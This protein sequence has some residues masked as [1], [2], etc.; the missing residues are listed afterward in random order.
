MRIQ[1]KRARPLALYAALLCGMIFSAMTLTGKT[2]YAACNCQQLAQ[3]VGAYCAEYG[4]VQ[5]FYCDASQLRF[6]C[7]FTS[8]IG[9]PCL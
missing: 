5:Y 1:M 6:K 8:F 9:G 2:A 4:G 7:A 3:E